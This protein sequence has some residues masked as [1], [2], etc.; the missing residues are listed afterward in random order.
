MTFFTKEAT[1]GQILQKVI[2][3][4]NETANALEHVIRAVSSGNNNLITAKAIKTHDSLN[5]RC[6]I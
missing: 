1:G 6:N 2:Y 4:L 3:Q 5:R